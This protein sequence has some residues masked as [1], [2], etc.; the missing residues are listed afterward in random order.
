MKKF[1][2]FIL[3]FCFSLRQLASADPI[4]GLW[5][6]LSEITGQTSYDI[7][8]AGYSPM[9]INNQ[10][11]GTYN[12]ESKLE[13]NLNADLLDLGADLNL[14]RGDFL[15]SVDYAFSFFGASQ[16]FRDRDWITQSLYNDYY[17]SAIGDT[18]ST[19][20]ETPARI[21]S[22]LIKKRLT[23]FGPND[24]CGVNVQLG[25]EH[26]NWG[27]FYVYNY[28]GFYG[29]FIIGGTSNQSVSAASPTPVLSY[30]INY[31]NYFIGL[32]F[33]FELNAGLH[34]GF[35][36][37]VGLCD[38]NDMDHHLLRDLVMQGNGSGFSTILKGDLRWDL[39]QGWFLTAYGQYI[40]FSNTGTQIQT[41][42]SQSLPA[43]DLVN[44]QVN[45]YQYRVGCEFSYDFNTGTK[46][47]EPDS[48]HLKTQEVLGNCF[49][50]QFNRKINL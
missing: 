7:T 44:D 28:A 2:W 8:F 48:K 10:I 31:N 49:S 32:N 30:E 43:S 23:S 20:V 41:D 33:D 24:G 1:I 16:S 27:T 37:D 22:L 45:S 35:G 4:I 15:V 34:G 50:A 11:V 42:Y 13:Y 5:T 46:G 9:T 19:G 40:T 39:A 14:G 38:F 17:N 3:L 25:Y 36:A 26:Q 29:P 12:G 6:G 47:Q 21:F 18:I